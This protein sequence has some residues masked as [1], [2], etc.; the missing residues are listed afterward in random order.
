MW[1]EQSP[2]WISFSATVFIVVIASSRILLVRHASHEDHLMNMWASI[3]AAGVLLREPTIAR[4]LE[5]WV[6][7]GLPTL[8][9]I[10]HWTTVASWVCGLGLFL[11][12]EYGPVRYRTGFRAA[13][14]FAVAV[15]V[16]F[17]VLSAP[18]RSEGISIADHGGWRYGVYVGLCWALPMVVAPYMG[19]RMAT[20]MR[21]T[22]TRYER[23]AVIIVAIAA[24][25]S[26]LPMAALP[27]F[28]GLGAAGVDTEFAR[29]GYQLTSDWFASGEP[30]LYIGALIFAAFIYPSVRAGAQL[31]RLRQLRPLWRELTDAAPEAVLV[32]R[33]N[34]RWNT[35]PAERLNRRRIEIRDA[36]KI[37]AR[38]TEPLPVA[39]EELIATTIDKGEQKGMRE[40]VALVI[41]AHLLGSGD[42]GSVTPLNG[43]RPQVPDVEVLLRLWTPAQSLLHKRTDENVSG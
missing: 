15:G 27:F 42:S 37:V 40:A 26:G 17:L 31:I 6:P 39:V 28:A 22:T 1:P 12:Y 29:H 9:D 5:G 34:D 43:T 14:A 21:H 2:T 18:A 23:A 13:I 3:T 16:A 25:V 11:R 32:L 7:G 10:W 30:Q 41:A 20:L 38:Y 33:W 35:G 24:V 19:R 8:F 4:H 36:V